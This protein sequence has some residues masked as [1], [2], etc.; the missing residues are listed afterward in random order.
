MGNTVQKPL[1]RPPVPAGKIRVCVAGFGVSHHTNRAGKIARAI[2]EAHP[3]KYETW[4]YFDSKGYRPDFLKQIKSELSQDQQQKFAAHKSSPFCWLEMP[5]GTRDA[6]GGRDFLSEWAMEMFP[7][8]ESI[9]KLAGTGPS[10]FEVMVDVTP[11]T[12][13]TTPAE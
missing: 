7:N 8:D 1:T 4:F 5:D 13:D 9:T 3:N 6:K 2:A 10:V 12:A 11:G